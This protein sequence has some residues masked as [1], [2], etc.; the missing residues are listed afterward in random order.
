MQMLVSL[1][2]EYT[3]WDDGEPLQVRQ[4][5]LRPFLNQ[6]RALANGYSQSCASCD[7]GEGCV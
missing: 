1:H 3:P 4:V 7:F 6:R 5:W 2:S